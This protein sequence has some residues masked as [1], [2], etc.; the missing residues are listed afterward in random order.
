MEGLTTEE[1]QVEEL[2]K[3]WRK[4]A[5]TIFLALIVGVGA[6]VATRY[7]MGDQ[8]GERVQASALYDTLLA[9]LEQNDAAVVTEQGGTLISQ[10]SDTPYAT[11]AALALAKVKYEQGDPTSA[12]SYLRWVLDNQDDEGMKHIARL[13]LARVMLDGGRASAALEL[14]NG[15]DPGEF[16]AAYEE[17]RGD[18]YVAL[19]KPDEARRAYM[20]ARAAPGMITDPQTLQM[21]LDEVGGGD[22]AANVAPADIGALIDAEPA[23]PAATDNVVAPESAAETAQTDNAANV[24]NAADPA[25]TTATSTPAKT[26]TPA[27]VGNSEAPASVD[28]ATPNPVETDNA[29]DAATPSPVEADNAAATGGAVSNPATE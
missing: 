20:A 7:W 1:E 18:I 8:E 22:V 9:G 28:A 4:N 3:W 27:T 11:L 12:E 17:L 16:G 29:V 25:N 21:K 6:L 15:L 2:R 13:R 19:N 5:K 14:M 10:F 26:E 24:G 23:A